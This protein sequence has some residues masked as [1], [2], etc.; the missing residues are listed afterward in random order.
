[1]PDL[2]LAFA[3]PWLLAALIV[4]PLIWWLLKVMPPAPKRVVFPATRL[5]FGLHRPEETPA[6]TPPW[7]IALR[8]LIA[9]LLI[10]ALAQ[11]LLNPGTKIAGA[12]PLVI[13]IDDGWPAARR[14]ERRQAALDALL[15]RAEREDR[16]VVLA[17]TAR[18]AADDDGPWERRLRATD[19]RRAAAAIMP[20]PWGTDRGA[21]LDRLE[22]LGLSGDAQVVWLADGVDDG[23]PDVAKRLAALGGLR[24]LGDPPRD[25]ARALTPPRFDA[26]SLRFT[27]LRADAVGSETL[28]LRAL[29]GDGV[30]LARE[31]VA[32]AADAAT[33]EVSLKAPAELR[34]RI[35]RVDLQGEASAGATVLIDERWRRHPVGLVAGGPIETNQPLLSEIHY[36]KRALDPFSEVRVGDIATLLQRPLS[37]LVLADIAKILPEDRTA[38]KRWIAAGGVLVRFA[39]PRLAQGSDDLVPVRLRGGGRVLGGALSWSRPAR[40]AP[41]DATSPFAGIKIPDDVR[42]RRQVLA[43]PSLDLGRKTWARLTDGTPLVTAER[44]GQGWLVLVHTTANTAWSDLALSGLFVEMLER[45]VGLG[46]GVAAEDSKGRLPPLQ[47]L[48]AFGR[49][50]TPPSSAGAIE[51]AAFDAT[52]IGPAH[53][54]GFYGTGAARRALNLSAG[55]TALDPLVVADGVAERAVYGSGGEIDFKPWLLAA[56]LI[57]ALADFLIGLA[58]R[59]L[60]AARVAATAA[61]ATVILVATLSPAAAQP[62]GDDAFALAATLETRLAYI[63]TGDA[64]VDEISRAGLVGLG[65]AL[66]ART[67][68]EPGAPMAVDVERNEMIF[69]PL[70]YWPVTPDFPTLSPEAEAKVDHYLRT[71]GIILFDTRDRGTRFSRQLGGMGPAGERLRLLLKDLDIPPLQPVAA[72]HVLTRSFYLMSAFPGRWAGGEP[73]VERYEG[74]VNDGVSPLVIG[75]NDWAAAWAIDD[76]RRPLFAVVP[77]GEAQR[78]QAFRFGIN[79]VMYAMTGNYKA[80]QVHLLAILQRLGQ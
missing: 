75:S 6:R 13:M 23:T 12:G 27:V 28:W 1:M 21:T 69:F 56:A 54:P 33:T 60:L 74:G 39:G 42:V 19:A 71:G 11:P 2:G 40:L 46:Q 30:L 8:L 4:L 64:S 58:L 17:P 66:T 52:A 31:P 55:M 43:E 62:T 5:L 57:L 14:W 78:E 16:A 29:D 24:L 22:R 47:T 26:D 59:G 50:G 53:P 7:L 61:V 10:T 20:K 48:D 72:D 18:R 80:D 3:F 65:L 45:L 36:L 70:I 49:L 38:L 35:V 63:R 44:R 34:N 25:G 73:W 67:S 32:F 9:A 51:A 37:M 41:F 68:I 76:R 15:A 79:L 77:G